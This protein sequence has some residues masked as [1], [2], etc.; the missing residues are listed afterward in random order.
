MNKEWIEKYFKEPKRLILPGIFVGIIVI[1]WFL[2]S[3]A[4]Q[5]KLSQKKVCDQKENE[6]KKKKEKIVEIPSEEKM[7][8]MKDRYQRLQKILSETLFHFKS[9]QKEYSPLRPLQF[10]EELLKNQQRLE[11]MSGGF[12]FPRGFGFVEYLDIKVPEEE[13]LLAFTKEMYITYEIMKILYKNNINKI[14]KVKRLGNEVEYYQQSGSQNKF[15]RIYS[16]S[17]VAESDFLN[18]M[19]AFRELA[20][21]DQHFIIVDELS[22]E[23]VGRDKIKASFVLRVVEFL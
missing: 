9:Q 6:I 18:F 14:T 13:E 17:F 3:S 20:Y 5:K 11:T 10:K 15:I 2:S 8:Q 12:D 22:V 23:K 16:V 7:V 19:E 4:N 21:T 1:G